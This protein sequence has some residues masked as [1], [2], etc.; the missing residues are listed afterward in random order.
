MWVGGGVMQTIRRGHRFSSRARRSYTDHSEW[1]VKNGELPNFSPPFL[2]KKEISDPAYK[3][4]YY[5]GLS[6]VH[7]SSKLQDQNA[8]VPTAALLRFVVPVDVNIRLT[9]KKLANLPSFLIV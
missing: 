5:L 6:I 8:W 2:K 3:L 1:N 4:I 7:T 9:K